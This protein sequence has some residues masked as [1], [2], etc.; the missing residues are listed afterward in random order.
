ELAPD[1]RN[2]RR[3]PPAQRR[4]LQAFLADVGYADAL[5]ARQGPEGLV[6]VDGHLRAELDPDQVV[7]VLVL[8]VDED[9]AATLL[10][11]LDP[12]AA[13]ALADP[14]ALQVLLAKAA[15]SEDILAARPWSLAPGLPQGLSDP[16]EIP[17]RPRSSRVGAGQVWALGE[18]RLICADATDPGATSRLMAGERADVLLTDPPYGVSYVGKTPE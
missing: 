4:A 3:H 9:E 13:M 2:Y 8:D 5:I 6:L 15:V 18:H 1:E 11:T 16:D 17:D 10:A 7:P 12:L 14:D